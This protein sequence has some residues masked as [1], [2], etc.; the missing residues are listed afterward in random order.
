[1]SADKAVAYAGRGA[2]LPTSRGFA[3]ILCPREAG[4][5]ARRAEGGRRRAL[6]CSIALKL[7]EIV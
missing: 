2:S 7:A 4:E 3:A 5:V 1:M 6:S